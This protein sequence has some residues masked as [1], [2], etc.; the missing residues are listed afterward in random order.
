MK[1]GLDY[2]T[3]SISSIFKKNQPRI[4]HDLAKE[5]LLEMAKN[6]SILLEI[7]QRHILSKDFF[8]QK[9]INPVIAFTIIDNP[10]ITMVA[11]FWLP[12]PDRNTSITH[13][14]IHHHGRLLLTSVAPFGPGYNSFIFK[15]G[16]SI[17]P[18]TEETSI[19]VEKEY[20]NPIYN[21]EFIDTYTPHVVF[22]PDSLSITYAT[23]TYDQRSL[24]D[25]IRK[26]TFLQKN[27][28]LLLKLINTFKKIKPIANTVE[29]FDFYPEKNQIY[30][31][32]DRVKY[33]VGTNENFIHNVFYILQEIDLRDLTEL[34]K[35]SN[36]YPK[37]IQEKILFYITQIEEGKKIKDLFDPI[38]LNI[39]KINFTR[40]ELIAG[41]SN[42]YEL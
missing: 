7:V 35:I 13:Q 34:K 19:V 12:L 24:L 17:N 14:S 21:L 30:A 26:N 20:H 2:Y 18:T 27:K 8:L 1:K 3:E 22:Y 6:K 38:H 37:E 36:Q 33:P 15:K 5:L 32:K 23:W 10:Y 29:Y 11:H 28:V 16:F 41:L 31:L 25:K 4:A 40:D 42:D 39:S 9:R